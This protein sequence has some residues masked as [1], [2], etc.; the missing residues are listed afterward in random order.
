MPLRGGSGG[1]R[2]GLGVGQALG[3]VFPGGGSGIC[4]GAVAAQPQLPLAVPRSLGE[5]LFYPEQPWQCVRGLWP[6]FLCQEGKGGR[7]D[8]P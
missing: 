2:P 8:H 1:A 7:W 4:L 5:A 6:W 3:M